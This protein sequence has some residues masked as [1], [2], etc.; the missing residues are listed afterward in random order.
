MVFSMTRAFVIEGTMKA[1]DGYTNV[2]GVAFLDAQP[3]AKALERMG[4]L[5]AKRGGLTSEEVRIV[6]AAPAQ[7]TLYYY[8]RSAASH[9]VTRATLSVDGAVVSAGSIP[10]GRN[11]PLPRNVLPAITGSAAVRLGLADAANAPGPADFRQR[12]CPPQPQQR[13][14]FA[15]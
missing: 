4:F 6:G 2:V 3:C 12:S 8:E 9:T 11:A 15:R 7:P 10:L 13:R 1:D 5:P 14:M